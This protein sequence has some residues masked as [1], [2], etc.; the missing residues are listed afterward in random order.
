LPR[1]AGSSRRLR[2]Y[3]VPQA[4]PI[5]QGQGRDR[6]SGVRK[7]LES[8]QRHPIVGMPSF[9]DKVMDTQLWQVSQLVAHANELPA[10]VKKVLVP[11]PLAN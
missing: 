3:D 5:I 8:G 4:D 7:L 9:K 6:R 10:S 11:D 1:P 2:D